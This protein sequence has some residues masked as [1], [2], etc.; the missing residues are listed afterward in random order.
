MTLLQTVQLERPLAL[1]GRVLLPSLMAFWWSAVVV[2]RLVSLAFPQWLP[3]GAIPWHLNPDKEG[4]AANA[5]SAAALATAALLT[6]GAAAA[7][8]RRGDGRFAVGGWTIVAITSAYL[9]WEEISG[10]HVTFGR[11]VIASVFGIQNSQLWPIA[12]SPLV[13]L[14]V[15]AA[16]GFVYKG[17][18]VREAR[19]LLVIGVAAWLL[20]LGNEMLN[21]FVFR[22]VATEAGELEVLLEETLEFGGALLVGSSAVA[23]LRAQRKE[24]AGPGIRRIAASALAALVI[25]GVCGGLFTALVYRPPVIDA[26]A[27]SDIGVY[28]TWIYAGHS[29]VQEFRLPAPVD[30]L[31]LSGAVHGS[32]GRAGTAIW[33]IIDGTGAGTGDILREGRIGIP[34]IPA[35]D[36]MYLAAVTIDIAPPLSGAE[37]RRL[38]LQLVN[39]GAPEERLSFQAV[40]DDRY[41]DGRLWFNGAPTSP[42]QDLEFV[43]YGPPDPTSSKLRTLWRL[44][45]SGWR[46]P[47]LLAAAAVDLTLITFV[48]VLLAAN[49]LSLWK[50]ARRP[51]RWRRE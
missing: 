48:P 16:A 12:A 25:V 42:D 33:R 20:A 8:H 34:A 44:V 43:A 2:P 37:G 51:A 6:L 5:V 26:R 11:K 32:D 36:D 4:S 40:K 45:T 41:A 29:I 19:A 21:P 10:F 1:L 46:W 3:S 9:A 50:R 15:L 30:R 49:E 24:S 18:H 28:T 27:N 35:R 13:A 22:A 23:A 7:S 47:V 17:L 14:F 38:A 31:E 39:D